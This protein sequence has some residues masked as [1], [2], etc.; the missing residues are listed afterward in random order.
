M[1]SGAMAGMQLGRRDE[2]EAVLERVTQHCVAEC[3]GSFLS[4]LVRARLF[5]STIGSFGHESLTPAPGPA[6]EGALD[7]LL[8][9]TAHRIVRQQS[10]LDAKWYEQTKA[11]LAGTLS[12]A[13]D[14][15]GQL[16]AEAALSETFVVVALAACVFTFYVALEGPTAATARCKEQM[17]RKQAKDPLVSAEHWNRLRRLSPNALTRPGTPL[18]KLFGAGGSFIPASLHPLIVVNLRT[19]VPFITFL[20]MSFARKAAK[21]SLTTANDDHACSR[22]SFRCGS[23]DSTC[24]SSGYASDGSS[25]LDSTPPASPCMEYRATCA[26]TEGPP[27]RIG[28]DIGGVLTREGD[29]SVSCQDEWQRGWEA[30]GAF[31]ALRRIVKLFG[32][33][34]VFLVS[35]VSPGGLMQR[36]VEK[37]LHQTCNIGSL[38]GVLQ[39]NIF[40]VKKVFGAEGKGPVA[41]ALGLSHFVDDKVEALTSVY[42][43][44][45]GNSAKAVRKHSGVLLHFAK[46]GVGSEKPH[47]SRNNTYNIRQFYRGVANWAEVLEELERNMQHA[48]QTLSYRLTVPPLEMSVEDCP[49]KELA[50]ESNMSAVRLPNGRRKLLLKPRTIGDSHKKATPQDELVEDESSSRSTALNSPASDRSAQ[51]ADREGTAQSLQFD[52]H[53]H[54]KSLFLTLR[55]LSAA[56]NVTDAVTWMRGQHVPVSA[57]AI[58]FQELIAR[59]VEMT[60][61]QS[62]G[63]GFQ[64]AARIADA[65]HGIFES[66]ECSKGLQLFFDEDYDELCEEFPEMPSI[67]SSE[68]LPAM[69]DALGSAALAHICPIA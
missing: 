61:M 55:Q 3:G 49:T 63:L 39:K 14:E 40:F 44:E 57:Q 43:D 9:S 6:D 1:A 7:K 47:Y 17:T 23:D 26:D 37:W 24:S 27:P 35:K 66:S 29:P 46:G 25:R 15:E 36:K 12:L 31:Q 62:R 34:N 41:S 45:A 33:E 69:R 51:C 10:S 42:D 50:A 20:L 2:L 4:G 53:T 64:F 30:P 54:Q 21:V 65:K 8:R 22:S 56:S 38:C 18:L 16:A 59:V 13:A 67:V 68:L 32:P 11:A 19:N 58:E 28:I 52:K 5:A 60:S 48:L